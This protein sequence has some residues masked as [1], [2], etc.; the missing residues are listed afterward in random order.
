MKYGLLGHKIAYSLSP[1]IHKMINRAG[2]DYEILDLS[3]EDLPQKLPEIVKGFSGFNVTIPHKQVI[4]ELCREIDPIAEKIGAVNTVKIHGGHWKGYNTDYLG[5]IET[6]KSSIPNYITYHPVIVGYGGVARA[7]IF[8]LQKLGFKAC[9][10]VGG[11]NAS[12]REEFIADMHQVLEL[13][14]HKKLPETKKLWINCTPVGGAKNP[15]VPSDFISYDKKDVLYDLN[16]SPCPTYLEKI[17]RS[18]GMVT[19]NGMN[20]L[21]S[22]AIEAQKIWNPDNKDLNCDTDKIIHSLAVGKSVS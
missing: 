20:M 18:K 14:G 13:T 11:I 4:M 15:S 17:A 21:V 16:Y 6:I 1:V 10:V 19:L 12:E 5:F 9:S 22:Q 3:P 2:I 7:V 8:S